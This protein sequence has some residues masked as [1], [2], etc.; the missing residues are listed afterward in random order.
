M[1]SFNTNSL[2]LM[3]T[4]LNL[5]DSVVTLYTKFNIK[6]FYILPTCVHFRYFYKSLNKPSLFPSTTLTAGCYNAVGV[7]NERYKLF[8]ST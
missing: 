7:F 8:L 1:K 6:K 4:S 3:K 2:H 5:N